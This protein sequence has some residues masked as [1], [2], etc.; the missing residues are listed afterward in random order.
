[1]TDYQENGESPASDS[2]QRGE[3][4]F[5]AVSEAIGDWVADE[6]IAVEREGSDIVADED[7]LVENISVMIAIAVD[8]ASS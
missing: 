8:G 5:D 6:S 4:L 3:E 2:S 1:M 7:E